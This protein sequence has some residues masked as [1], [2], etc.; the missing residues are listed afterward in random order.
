MEAAFITNLFRAAYRGRCNL[1]VALRRA[2]GAETHVSRDGMSVNTR[3][4][5]CNPVFTR[6]AG[7]SSIAAFPGC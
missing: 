7:G 2:S 4:T 5:G 1:G 3:S 6:A